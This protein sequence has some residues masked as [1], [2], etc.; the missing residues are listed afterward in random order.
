MNEKRLRLWPQRADWLTPLR[1]RIDDS[2]RL[3][4]DA[5]I[6]CGGRT[7]PISV[8]YPNHFPAFPSR[9]IAARRS[10]T[11]V[12]PPVRSREANSALNTARITGI[13]ILREPTW[14]RVRIASWRREPFSG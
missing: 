8:R 11:L 4:W 14:S 3:I 1:W 2:L 7:F 9:R 5:D 12:L 10:D 6:S 13:R